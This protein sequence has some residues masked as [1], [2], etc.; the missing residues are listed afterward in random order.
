MKF[1]ILLLLYSFIKNQEN[2]KIL[3]LNDNNFDEFI[4]KT[5][6]AIVLFY[7]SKKVLKDY[8]KYLIKLNNY[9]C[10]FFIHI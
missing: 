10:Y 8:S 6:Y 9:I 2:N 1:F 5:E 4:N 3:E 7:P